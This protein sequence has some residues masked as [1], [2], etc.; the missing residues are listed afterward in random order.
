MVGYANTYLVNVKGMGNT[1]IQYIKVGSLRSKLEYMLF[2]QWL[3]MILNLQ[4]CVGVCT[5]NKLYKVASQFR[6]K[7]IQVL[8]PNHA[9]IVSKFST[10]FSNWKETEY[11]RQFTLIQSK[12]PMLLQKEIAKL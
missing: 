10:I 8:F 2:K 4:K 6:N 9:D 5:G 7:G 12:R 3:S 11:A 1:T